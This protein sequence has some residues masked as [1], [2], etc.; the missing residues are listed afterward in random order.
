MSQPVFQSLRVITPGMRWVRNYC[1][2]TLA[3]LA[4]V[5]VGFAL[6]ELLVERTLSERLARASGAGEEESL[7]GREYWQAAEAARK[8]LIF[9]RTSGYLA[10]LNDIEKPAADPTRP[11]WGQEVYYSDDPRIRDFRTAHQYFEKIGVLVRQGF[12]NFALVFDLVAFPDDFW[13]EGQEL[14]TTLSRHWNP[15]QKELRDFGDGIAYLAWLPFASLA[16]TPTNVALLSVLA[17][18]F[19]GCLGNLRVPQAAQ[20]VETPGEERDNHL[21]TNWEEQKKLSAEISL[22]RHRLTFLREEPVISAVR[23][24]MV[25]LVYL[26]TVL[27]ATNTDLNAGLISGG[28]GTQATLDGFMTYIRFA[29]FVSIISFAFGYDPSSFEQILRRATTAF[30]SK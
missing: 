10:L 11:R 17:G 28:T 3:L 24:L 6:S 18:Y 14:R 15:G 16:F 30:D 29:G 26:A 4:I 13:K 23:G 8:F 20:A 9:K 1:L 19:G 2:L 21:K 22:A 5:Y 25:Y 7:F 12:L 27:L